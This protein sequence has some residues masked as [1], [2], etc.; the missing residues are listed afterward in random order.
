MPFSDSSSF[1]ETNTI[2]G[3][4]PHKEMN[5]ETC[6]PFCGLSN[7]GSSCWLNSVL[8]AL[9]HSQMSCSVL[10]SPNMCIDLTGKGTSNSEIAIQDIVKVWRYMKNSANFGTN[11]PDS[12]LK[13]AF[14]SVV[15]AIPTFSHTEKQDAHEFNSHVIADM[16]NILIDNSLEYHHTEECNVCKK[17]RI[18]ETNVGQTIVLDIENVNNVSIQTLIDN[19]FINENQ[20]KFCNTCLKE[21][22]H[23]IKDKNITK[24]PK[25]LIILLRRYKVDHIGP[26]RIV[27]RKLH[28]HIHINSEL[29]LS[30]PEHNSEVNYSFKSAVCHHGDSTSAGHYN[31]VVKHK[32]DFIRCDDEKISEVDIDYTLSTAYLVIFDRTEPDLPMYVEPFLKCLSKAEGLKSVVKLAKSS[33]SLTGNSRKILEH[34]CIGTLHEYVMESIQQK[35]ALDLVM[36]NIS[37]ASFLDKFIKVFIQQDDFLKKLFHDHFYIATKHITMCKKCGLFDSHDQDCLK[38]MVNQFTPDSVNRSLSVLQGNGRVFQ[39]CGCMPEPEV[40]IVSLPSTIIVHV[41]EPQTLHLNDIVS[42]N[43]SDQYKEVYPFGTRS[44]NLKS[45]F[46]QQQGQFYSLVKT[47]EGFQ[48]NGTGDIMNDLSCFQS[49][50]L[51]FNRNIVIFDH[52][53]EV[54]SMLKKIDEIPRAEMKIPKQLKTNI[55]NPKNK[56]LFG[57]RLTKN[58]FCS[59]TDPSGWLSSDNIDVYLSLIGRSIARTSSKK[60][61]AVNS[62]WFCQKLLKNNDPQMLQWIFQKTESKEK[63]FDNE[64]VLIPVNENSLHWTLVIVEIKKQN[65]IYCNS[66][67]N[68]RNASYICH[69]IWRYLRYEALLHNNL[70]LEKKEWSVMYYNTLPNFPKQTDGSSCGVYVCAVAKAIVGNMRLVNESNLGSFRKLMV[71]EILNSSISFS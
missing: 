30:N 52:E 13:S 15:A 44:Y 28:N 34:L 64:F 39:M 26:K 4:K 29:V 10:E 14:R 38:I 9:V 16:A 25:S 2:G 7:Y 69:Q 49:V 11:V 31:T 35:M 60:V 5:N 47:V 53:T 62:V 41:Q 71:S 50:F 6:R 65:I 54:R 68:S 57:V 20:E 61:Y 22:E 45:V 32:T 70:L 19:V 48:Q 1:G 43:I 36:N 23:T 21:T 55:G 3:K 67:S 17:K 46:V 27:P 56:S 40:F 66:L 59:L 33:V 37:V 18:R 12:I 24:Y 8:Q 63:W 42:L 58:F 51:F